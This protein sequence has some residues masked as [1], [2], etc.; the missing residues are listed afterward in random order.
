MVNSFNF[1]PIHTLSKN[2]NQNHKNDDLKKF[3]FFRNTECQNPYFI[4][5]RRKGHK[6]GGLSSLLVGTLGNLSKE[7]LYS[8]TILDVFQDSIFDTRPPP[9]RILLQ[10]PESEVAYRKLEFL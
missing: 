5:Q 10:T 3:Y 8:D 7:L 6:T 9:Y 4:L 2:V 1:R